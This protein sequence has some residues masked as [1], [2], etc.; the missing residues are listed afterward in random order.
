M[1]GNTSR[2]WRGEPSGSLTSTQAACALILLIFTADFVTTP[3]A[4][5]SEVPRHFYHPHGLAYY[6][7]KYTFVHTIEGSATALHRLEVLTRV[8]LVC[9]MCGFVTNWSLVVASISCPAARVADGGPAR[10]ARVPDADVG[11]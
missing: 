11:F 10:A 3:L 8:S 2:R 1:T 5:T 6:L 9:A 4:R 7:D